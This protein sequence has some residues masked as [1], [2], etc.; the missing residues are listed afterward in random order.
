MSAVTARQRPPAAARRVGHCLAAAIN[1]VLLYMIDNRPGWDAVPFLT[2]DTARVVALVNAS[3]IVGLTVDLVQIVH[4]PPWLV[5]L[6]GVTTTAVGAAVLIRM[7]QVFPFDFG[8][9]AFD[10]PLLAH[11]LLALGVIG[12]LAGFATQSV[13]LASSLREKADVCTTRSPGTGQTRPR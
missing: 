2:E 13:A 3:L 7:W 9:T 6:G 10:W 5:A 12:S 11:L 8:D 4:D 1:I